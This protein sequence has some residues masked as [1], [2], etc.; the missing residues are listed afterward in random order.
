MGRKVGVMLL[1]TQLDR[2]MTSQRAQ[3]LFMREFFRNYPSV[4]FSAERVHSRADLAKFL[5]RA[6]RNRAVQFVHIVAHGRSSRTR[7]QLV[8]TGNERVDLRVGR[9]QRLFRGLVDKILF[10]SCCE[11]G[12]DNDLMRK[13]LKVSGARAIFSYVDEIEDEQAFVIEPLFYHL[14][15]R[16]ASE[17]SSAPLEEMYQRL[18]FALHFLGIDKD[19]QAMTRSLLAADIRVGRRLLWS[20]DDVRRL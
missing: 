19:R 3:I 11:I 12:A 2:E 16:A 17:R 14:A 5:D 4:D 10:F 20:S 8:L 18:R 15:H 13:L 1:E 7:S 6:R 9:N